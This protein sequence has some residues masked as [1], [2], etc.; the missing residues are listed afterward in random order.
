MASRNCLE[1]IINCFA[2]SLWT[3]NQIS[4]CI[5]QTSSLE[6]N[7]TPR[8]WWTNPGDDRRGNIIDSQGTN[9]LGIHCGSWAF[10]TINLRRR[11]LSRSTQYTQC[12]TDSYEASDSGLTMQTRPFY[13]NVIT[14]EF[15]IQSLWNS[16]VIYI[17]NLHWNLHSNSNVNLPSNSN[18]R[19][20]SQVTSR[21]W[22]E[23]SNFPRNLNLR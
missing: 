4:I 19:W 3:T 23:F 22:W 21:S 7:Q 11:F 14:F 2:W 16:N 20:I 12:R 17:R 6:P 1:T 8:I 18:V 10:T 9:S 13:S 15:W 5:A